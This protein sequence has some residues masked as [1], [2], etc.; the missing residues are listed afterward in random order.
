MLE[1][2]DVETKQIELESGDMIFMISDGVLDCS[3]TERSGKA[4]NVFYRESDQ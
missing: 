3:S 4:V 2:T 1:E